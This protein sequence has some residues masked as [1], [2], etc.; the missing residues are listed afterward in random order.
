MSI[1]QYYEH[2]KVKGLKVGR[3]NGG[4]N[5]QF[6]VYRIGD[7]VID[8]G[9]SNQWRYVRPYLSEAPVRQL[10][11]THHHEDHTGNARRIARHFKLIPKAPLLS[12]KKLASG[13]ATPLI[14]KIVW[15]SPQ[16]VNTEPLEDIEYLSDGSPI[17]PVATP[18][19]AKDLTCFHLPDKGY[20][21]SGDLYIARTIKIMRSDEKLTEMISSLKKAIALDFDTLFCPHGG[22]FENGRQALEGKLHNILKL[23]NQVKELKLKG[24]DEQ[25][26]LIELLGPEDWVAKIS[27]GNL[28]RLNLIKQCSVVE[29]N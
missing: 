5:T 6:I 16:P 3:L 8:T 25:Q 28:S 23:C 10:L 2:K 29:L 17:V 19:H 1:R 18:G 13:Y 14:Q 9:P 11:L 27:S 22:I 24:W 20:L 21:F 7:T 4:I 12:Q 15:G 26:I